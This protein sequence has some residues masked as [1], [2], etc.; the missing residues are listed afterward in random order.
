MESENIIFLF[1]MI[2]C[3]ALL[4][5]IGIY[6]MR[7]E[8]PMWFW[9]GSKVESEEI[10]DVPAYNRANGIMWILYSLPMWLATF[11]GLKHTAVTVTIILLDSTVGIIALIVAYKRIYNK[12]K[13]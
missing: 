12:Y 6:V 8:E 4:T 9:S 5:G 1:I 11:I 3:S 2:F 10:S 7:R 13:K